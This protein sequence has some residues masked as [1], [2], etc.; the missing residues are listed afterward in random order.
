MLPNYLKIRQRHFLKTPDT[1][2]KELLSFVSAWILHTSN[3]TCQIHRRYRSSRVRS[4]RRRLRNRCLGTA[5]AAES[6]RAVGCWLQGDMWACMRRKSCVSADPRLWA[7][8]FRW[9]LQQVSSFMPSLL[10][11]MKSELTLIC[12]LHRFGCLGHGGD[13]WSSGEE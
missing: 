13:L 4:H 12:S 11:D 7:Q 10:W 9:C 6:S 8:W 2:T 1:S 3:W 5:G